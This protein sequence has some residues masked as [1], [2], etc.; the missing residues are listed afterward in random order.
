MNITER[1]DETLD[2]LCVE[3]S[4]VR[5]PGLHFSGILRS[6]C[7]ELEPKK[8]TNGPVDP[9]WT[10]PGFSFERVLETA[11]QARRVDIIRPGE[12]ECD[13]V[14]CSPDGV[15]FDDDGGARLEEFKFTDLG[16]PANTL[17]LATE[18]KYKKYFWQIGGYCY[19]LGTNRARLRV[20]WNRGDY[21]KI[22]RAYKV[23]DIEW[24]AGETE[25]IWTMCLDHAHK[26][27]LWQTAAEGPRS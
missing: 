20:L 14:I 26:H 8:F 6:I 12:F 22:R 4:P 15:S 10:E 18:P 1:E 9:L 5:T 21:K 7:Q 2:R 19:V 23:Y 17:A 27:H 13:E 11:F 3:A 25:R 16:M 24:T